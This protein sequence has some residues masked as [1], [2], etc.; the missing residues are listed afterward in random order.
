MVHKEIFIMRKNQ[1]NCFNFETRPAQFVT[2]KANLLELEMNCISHF[3][4]KVPQ[5]QKLISV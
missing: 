5:R 2:K 3:P 1:A 4:T